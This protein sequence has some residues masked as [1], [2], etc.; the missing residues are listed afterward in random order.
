MND[1]YLFDKADYKLVEKTYADVVEIMND[2]IIIENY[3]HTG[4]RG[5]VENNLGIIYKYEI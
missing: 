2:D 1:T 5:F 3:L 4:K